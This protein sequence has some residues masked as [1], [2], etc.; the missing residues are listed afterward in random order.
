MR[1]TCDPRFPRVRRRNAATYQPPAGAPAIQREAYVRPNLIGRSEST[2]ADGS[3]HHQEA[4]TRPFDLL[5]TRHYRSG[6]G[7]ACR[8]HFHVLAMPC[9]LR[10]SLRCGCVAGG[11]SKPRPAARGG[12]RYRR[13]VAKFFR[14]YSA[15]RN[16]SS[17]NPAEKPSEKNR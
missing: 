7:H 11:H 16:P 13:L 8:R 17:V 1:Y 6:E 10:I 3:F 4:C 14:K 2:N 5:R 12:R 15:S 9:E